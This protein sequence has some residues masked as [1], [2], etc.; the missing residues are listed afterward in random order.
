MVGQGRVVSGRGPEDDTAFRASLR[1]WAWV[2]YN[3][4]K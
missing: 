4:T 2:H 1:L 3:Y